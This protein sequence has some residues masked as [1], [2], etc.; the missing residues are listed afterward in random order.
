MSRKIKKY[1]II[2]LKTK[3]N[4]KELIGEEYM[5]WHLVLSIKKEGIKLFSVNSMNILE[6]GL[7]EFIKKY[8]VRFYG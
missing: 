2:M 4:K 3:R 6:F 7:K 8:E 5:G 1:D